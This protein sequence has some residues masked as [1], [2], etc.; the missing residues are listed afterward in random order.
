MFESENRP[1]D[2]RL[3]IADKWQMITAVMVSPAPPR[4]LSP[5]GGVKETLAGGSITALI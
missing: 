3:Y 4:P 5:S 1:V 2:G